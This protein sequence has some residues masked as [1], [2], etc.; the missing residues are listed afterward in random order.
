MI[1]QNI[2]AIQFLFRI[3]A[4]LALKE[5]RKLVDQEGVNV[6]TLCP[7]F[8]HKDIA[9]FRDLVGENVGIC[10]SRGDSNSSSFQS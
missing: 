3:K 10:V 4:K 8:S 6:I 2:H 5:C 1:L 9:Q 7:G